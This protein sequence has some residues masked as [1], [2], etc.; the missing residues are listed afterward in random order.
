MKIQIMVWTLKMEAAWSSKTLVSYHITTQHQN[1]EEVHNY[2]HVL[3]IRSNNH[4]SRFLSSIYGINYFILKANYFG[5]PLIYVPFFFVC[6]CVCVCVS[7][8]YKL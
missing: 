4:K 7:S 8:K 3:C 1:P 6:V 5:K 2:N